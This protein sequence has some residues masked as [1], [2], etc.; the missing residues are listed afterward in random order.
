MDFGICL[1][2][3]PPVLRWAHI[4]GLK[5]TKT[6][7]FEGQI[8]CPERQILFFPEI[9]RGGVLVEPSMRMRCV[10]PGKCRSPEQSR[11]RREGDGSLDLEEE[12]R[13]RRL[14]AHQFE[15][16]ALPLWH[17]PHGAR[18]VTHTFCTRYFGIAVACKSSFLGAEPFASAG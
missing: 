5:S 9:V 2:F 10:K 6:I 8:I 4:L 17:L 15:F 13:S 3:A 7:C 12:K 16:C 14:R 1:K 18:R 11:S